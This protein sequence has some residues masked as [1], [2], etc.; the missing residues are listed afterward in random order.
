VRK[1][2]ISSADLLTAEDRSGTYKPGV[3]SSV[4]KLKAFPSL[5][6]T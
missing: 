3:S 4:I 1:E 6:E 5:V 2:V